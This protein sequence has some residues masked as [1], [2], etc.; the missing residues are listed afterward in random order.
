MK[1]KTQKIILPRLGAVFLRKTE[2]GF[3][4]NNL[5]LGPVTKTRSLR[6]TAILII[7]HCWR[8]VRL[9]E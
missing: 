9:S 1:I 5:L 8:G 7:G 3:L 4:G 6:R 2:N